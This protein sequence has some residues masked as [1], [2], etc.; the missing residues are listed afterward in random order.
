MGKGES[1]LKGP[2]GPARASIPKPEFACPAI[3]HQLL[4]YQRGAVPDHLSL[5]KINLEL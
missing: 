2:P 5:K 1:G 4:C 3:F